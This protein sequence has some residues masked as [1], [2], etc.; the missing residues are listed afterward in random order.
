MHVLYKKIQLFFDYIWQYHVKRDG[1]R[2]T[3]QCCNSLKSVSP[4]LYALVKTYSSCILHPIQ[5]QFLALAAKQN[6][7]LFG[8]DTKDAFDHFPAPEVPTFMMIDNQYYK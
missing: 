2:R 3:Q 4:I 5:C 7:W 1:Q 6:Y 8:G